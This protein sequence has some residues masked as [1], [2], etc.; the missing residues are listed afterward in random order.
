MQKALAPAEDV[1]AGT[2]LTAIEGIREAAG[3][4]YRGAA[5]VG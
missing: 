2:P 4:P 5:R 1:I 3:L